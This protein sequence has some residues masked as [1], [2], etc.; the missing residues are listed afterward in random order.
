MSKAQRQSATG[1]HNDALS[2][3]TKDTK[4]VSWHE[5]PQTLSLALSQRSSTLGVQAQ[6]RQQ[7]KTSAAATTEAQIEDEEHHEDDEIYVQGGDETT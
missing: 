1:R 3:E 6:L 2:E 7:T 5:V 4:N